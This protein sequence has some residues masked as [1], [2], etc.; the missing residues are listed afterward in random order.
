MII[1]WD[2]GAYEYGAIRFYETDLPLR[3]ATAVLRAESL[4]YKNR[5]P[6]V[7]GVTNQIDWT[8]KSRAPEVPFYS[9]VASLISGVHRSYNAEAEW[10]HL[11]SHLTMDEMLMLLLHWKARVVDDE[12]TRSWLAW[13]REE[14]ERR[15]ATPI[16]A[17]ETTP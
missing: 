13:M 6:R 7:I 1:I 16:C 10:G 11:R 3:V 9:L 5:R 4:R 2:T 14:T 8:A 12:D 17:Q 15:W